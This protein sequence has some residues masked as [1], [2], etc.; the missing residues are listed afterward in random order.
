MVPVLRESTL[1]RSC[2]YTMKAAPSDCLLVA[3]H[4]QKEPFLRLPLSPE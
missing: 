4:P 3:H 1:S 2:C